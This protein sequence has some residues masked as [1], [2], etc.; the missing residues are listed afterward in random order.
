MIQFAEGRFGGSVAIV[1]GPTSPER[2]E[3]TQERLLS[4]AQSGLHQPSD[5]L[6]QDLHFTLC[7]GDQQFILIFAQGVP[8]KVEARL[9]GGEDGLLL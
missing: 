6:A 9:D 3:L 2:V 8:Q 5:L 7:G 4:E 1:V